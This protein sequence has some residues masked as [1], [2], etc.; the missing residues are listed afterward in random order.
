MLRVELRVGKRM[1]LVTA[2]ARLLRIHCSDRPCLRAL[3]VIDPGFSRAIEPLDTEIAWL[4]QQNSSR[5]YSSHR[6]VVSRK[7]GVSFC[8]GEDDAAQS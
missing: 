1:G 8:Y 2:W 4:C 5:L 6:R 7:C 3:A